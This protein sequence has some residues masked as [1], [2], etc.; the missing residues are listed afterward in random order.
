MAMD[1]ALASRR[2]WPAYVA[3]CDHFATGEGRT[4]I[5]A[6]GATVEEA[7]ILFKEMAPA[8]FAS[9]MRITELAPEDAVDLN[10]VTRWIPAGVIERIAR[11]DGPLRFFGM[12]HQN[13]S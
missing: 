3:I 11:S 5:V 8:Y 7:T 9:S 10:A 2:S 12:F 6:I 13:L 1:G 4:V